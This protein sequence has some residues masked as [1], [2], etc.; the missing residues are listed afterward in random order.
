MPTKSRS[1]LS[2]PHFQISAKVQVFGNK[3]KFYAIILAQLKLK[4]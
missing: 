4:Y 1:P 3:N 2:W